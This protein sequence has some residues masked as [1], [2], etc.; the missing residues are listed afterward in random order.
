MAWEVFCGIPVNSPL[1]VLLLLLKIETSCNKNQNKLLTDQIMD[2]CLRHPEK[3]RRQ[4]G[5]NRKVIYGNWLT[6]NRWSCF[7]DQVGAGDSPA[8]KQHGNFSIDFNTIGTWSNYSTDFFIFSPNCHDLDAWI[9]FS[10]LTWDSQLFSAVWLS[11][12]TAS[13]LRGYSSAEHSSLHFSGY[14]SCSCHIFGNCFSFFHCRVQ[15]IS[16]DFPTW[17][18]PFSPCS[19]P[20]LPL[21]ILDRK[22]QQNAA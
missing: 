17:D 13:S 9:G 22:A 2:K 19:P 1:N 7:I 14:Q 5:C 20:K 3:R 15:G 12:L 8:M 11:Q 18:L 6:L 10:W 16:R 4:H 21:I